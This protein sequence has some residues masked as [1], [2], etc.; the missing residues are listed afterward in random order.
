MNICAAVEE[1]LMLESAD[2]VKSYAQQK[3]PITINE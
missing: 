2:E 1:V 3:M